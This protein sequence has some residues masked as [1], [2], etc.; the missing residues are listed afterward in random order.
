MTTSVF[1]NGFN[2]ELNGKRASVY[3]SATYPK[4][5]IVT[6]G[7]Y[8]KAFSGGLLEGMAHLYDVAS[9]DSVNTGVTASK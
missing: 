7:T 4:I 6:Y 1:E 3:T 8:V 2:L 9:T 5:T